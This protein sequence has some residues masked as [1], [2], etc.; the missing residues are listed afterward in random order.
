MAANKMDFKT[1]L[2]SFANDIESK[3]ALNVRFNPEDQLKGAME[4]LLRAVG[5]LLALKITVVTETQVQEVKGRPDMGLTVDSLLTGYVELKAPGKGTDTGRL[6]GTDKAQWEKFQNL[7]NLLYT[8]GN[9]WALYRTGERVGKVLRFSGD[10]TTEGARAVSVADA[11][12]LLELLREFL[13]W[14]PL[15]PATPRA[16]AQMLAP[17]TRLLR[18]D[19]MTAL[20]DPDSNLTNLAN[21][22]REYLFPEADDAQFADAYAQ[23]LTY[24]LLLA[25]F[26]GAEALTIQQAAQTI[27]AGHRLLADT[28][29]IFGDE[30]AREQIEVPLRLLERVIAAVDV[31]K[32]KKDTDDLWLYFY[33]D[34]LAEYDP[35][36]RKE[37][38]VYYTPLPVVQA[39]V[40]LVA[41]LLQHRFDAEF[42]FVDSNVVTLD[43]ASGTGT[44]I[45]TAVQHAL[46]QVERARGSGMRASAATNAAKNIHAFE[47]LVGPYAVAH[48]RLT[49]QILAEG[50]QIP[51]DGVHVYLS[52]TLSSPYAPPPG[53]RPLLA[54]PL[55]EEYKRAQT[56]KAQT[57]VI[58]CIGNPPYDRQ[59]M[60]EEEKST[61]KRKGGWVRFGDKGEEG[62][63]ILKDFL[64]PLAHSRQ[65][66][67]AKNLYN[68]YVYFWRWALWKVFGTPAGTERR[69]GIVSFITASSYLRGPGFAGMR[70]VMRETLDD[71]WIIDL[72]GDNLGA[73]K[74]ENVFAIQT[75]VAIAIGVRYA[76]PRPEVPARVRY[77][78][79]CPPVSAMC[80][81]PGR[82]R[83][84]WSSWGK[85]R[86]L[87][88]SVGAIACQG[89]Q[90]LSCPQAIPPTGPGRF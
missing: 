25:R 38:G 6:R 66:V 86:G 82:R 17:I 84:N 43:P 34:F 26:S 10:V 88:T 64:D 57:Q 21:D 18:S 75:P 33:E 68:D 41:E 58:V 69:P 24:A 74:S 54:K 90:R 4:N 7:P 22:W 62:K 61:W 5:T 15:P 67:H 23:T 83:K 40:R 1:L 48:L 19:V 14:E 3:F 16:L 46:D 52:D 78:R 8:D 70:Q 28:L 30:A 85:S 55:T 50:G 45:L 71:L 51:A 80:D 42:S 2:E 44:Y 49:Q 53:Y 60:T 11:G 37:R 20:G 13:A 31:D 73:R 76:A 27:H 47:I 35:N 72:E 87:M 29:K 77:A 39:Q 12:A 56:V 65:G 89:G 63:G 81:S 32:L 59:Q 36:M 9:E 79:R